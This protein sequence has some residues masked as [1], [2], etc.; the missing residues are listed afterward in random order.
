MT[1]F[2]RTVVDDEFFSL[3]EMEKFA[4]DGEKEFFSKQNNSKNGDKS[5]GKLNDVSDDD[6]EDEIGSTQGKLVTYF[7]EPRGI[8][9]TV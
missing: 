7:Y 5:I 4:E 9:N 2:P 8:L 6:S 1:Y 3:R